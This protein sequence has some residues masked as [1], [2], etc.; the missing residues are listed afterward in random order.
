MQGLKPNGRESIGVDLSPIPLTRLLTGFL[1]SRRQGLSPR[2]AEWYRDYL[3]LARDV[4]GIGV[5]SLEISQFL[6]GLTCSAGGKHAYYRALKTFYNWLYSARSGYGLIPHDN[7]M[8]GVDAPKVPKRIL[9]SLTRGQVDTLIDEA[10]CVRDKAIISLFADSGL[11]LSEL[12]NIN[13]KDIDWDN[14]LI[15]VVCKGN[16]EGLA[17]FVERTEKYLKEWLGQY[18]ANGHLWDIRPWGIIRMLQV[19]RER[20]GLPCNPH[21]FRRTFACLLAKRG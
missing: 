21:T 19:L 13:P 10:S 15:K 14:R 20:T 8:D 12:A 5:T 16:K 4:V 1:Q 6:N 7:P 2:T 17:P 18:H 9:P 11:R 3:N